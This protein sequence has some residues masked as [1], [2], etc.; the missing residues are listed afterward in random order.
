L[1]NLSWYAEVNDD[2]QKKFSV[3][4]SLSQEL[5]DFT[6]QRASFLRISPS[7][8]VSIVLQNDHLANGIEGPL[9]VLPQP[10]R[11]KNE[12]RIT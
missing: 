8:L 4:Y 6:K 3:S 2:N 1:P 10:S 12:H 11:K 9:V 5:I 7:T